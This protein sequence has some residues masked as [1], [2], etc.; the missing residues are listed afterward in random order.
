MVRI[1]RN[2]VAFGNFHIDALRVLRA[3][4]VPNLKSYIL[5]T[6]WID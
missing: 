2:Y 4:C 1:E 3:T 5:T 6:Q